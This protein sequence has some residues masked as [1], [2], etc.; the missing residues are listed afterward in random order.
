VSPTAT[1]TPIGCV[2]DCDDS[3]TVTVD[4]LVLGVNIALGTISLEECPAFDSNH[5][6]QVTVD[7]LVEAVG[8]ALSGCAT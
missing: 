6:S 2:G 3:G 8:K 4:E 5:D 7:E 1:A